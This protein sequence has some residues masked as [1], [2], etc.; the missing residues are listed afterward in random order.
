MRREYGEQDGD[1]GAFP[2]RDV[3]ISCAHLIHRSTYA[4]SR[5]WRALLGC[6]PRHRAPSCAA[7]AASPPRFLRP[8]TLHARI[9]RRGAAEA[10]NR[11]ATT[12]RT[13]AGRRTGARPARAA[14]LREA[15][16]CGVAG[17]P[18]VCPAA[19]PVPV[20]TPWSQDIWPAIREVRRS[21]AIRP[22]G[23]STF[24]KETRATSSCPPAGNRNIKSQQQVMRTPG[25]AAPQGAGRA[26]GACEWGCA[27]ADLWTA[28]GRCLRRAAGGE[29]ACARRTTA[30]GVLG[31]LR[32]VRLDG[33]GDWR[34]ER[35]TARARGRGTSHARGRGSS[36]CPVA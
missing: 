32:V 27:R 31:R 3:R 24:A 8:P 36:C 5:R 15:S 13:G 12:H 10:A 6:G 35:R 20:I 33:G 18:R 21:A 14:P 26:G 7:S 29:P 28:R 19:G 2:G 22:A 17:R 4:G 25:G 23:P 9:L 30:G 1:G 11:G 34:R 16:L